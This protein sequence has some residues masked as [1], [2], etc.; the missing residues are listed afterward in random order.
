MSTLQ[1]WH[2]YLLVFGI[3]LDKNISTSSRLGVGKLEHHRLVAIQVGNPQFKR[4]C[5]CLTTTA[6]NSF[7]S[8]G[9]KKKKAGK[10]ITHN[11]YVL[12]VAARDGL[13]RAKPKKIKKGIII[14]RR[15]DRTLSGTASVPGRG[16]LCVASNSPC[17]MTHH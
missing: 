5:V 15:R 6:K 8:I 10:K 16:G 3:F 14:S 13:R 9:R 4:S 7:R 12:Q 17:Q 11:M 1:H 2:F